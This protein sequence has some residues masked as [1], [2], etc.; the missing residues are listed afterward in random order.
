MESLRP[1]RLPRAYNCGLREL[2]SQGVRLGPSAES[3]LGPLDEHP[4]AAEVRKAQAK[5]ELLQA[6]TDKLEGTNALEEAE[7]VSGSPSTAKIEP[8]KA[9]I[10]QAERAIQLAK[11][12]NKLADIVSERAKSV[13][14]ATFPGT[15]HKVSSFSTPEQISKAVEAKLAKLGP[16]PMMTSKLSEASA[17]VHFVNAPKTAEHLNTANKVVGAAGGVLYV[18]GLY[19]AFSTDSTALDKLTAI[20]AR[21]PYLGQAVGFVDAVSHGDLE[22]EAVNLISLGGLVVAE[23][24]PGV[25]VVVDVSML[26]YALTEMAVSEYDEYEVDKLYAKAKPERDSLWQKR[27][28]YVLDTQ[29][30]PRYVPVVEELHKR[31]QQSLVS[32]WTTVEVAIDQQLRTH[33]TATTPKVEKQDLVNAAYQA[34]KNLRARVQQSLQEGRDRFHGYLI[35][36]LTDAME[37]VT[38]CGAE[39]DCT[40]LN[41]TEAYA[42]GMSAKA[43]A[44]PT[45]AAEVKERL[46][47]NLPAKIEEAALK[48]RIEEDVPGALEVSELPDRPLLPPVPGNRVY[49]ATTSPYV[50]T[51]NLANLSHADLTVVRPL[52]GAPKAGIRD[53]A[54]G[55]YAFTGKQCYY[56]KHSAES[57]ILRGTIRDCLP[58]L[59]EPFSEGIDAVAGWDVAGSAGSNTPY[60][61]W[62]IFRNGS[63]VD[64]SIFTGQIGSPE[65]INLPD[66]YANYER[67]DAVVAGNAEL[68]KGLP[69]DF[70][71]FKDGWFI[72][73][74]TVKGLHGQPEEASSFFK[75]IEDEIYSI[76]PGTG[77][78]AKRKLFVFAT[79]KPAE[80]TANRASATGPSGRPAS[81][82]R[83]SPA[84]GTAAVPADGFRAH[85]VPA[86]RQHAPP[87]VP[88]QLT[89]GRHGTA[90][91]GVP[92]VPARVSLIIPAETSIKN[93]PVVPDE[94]AM[95]MREAHELGQPYEV[96]INRATYTARR[97][98]ANIHKEAYRKANP[99]QVLG[100]DA[101]EIPMAYFEEGGTATANFK[102]INKSH[103][104]SLGTKIPNALGQ[105]NTKTNPYKVTYPD[106]T[107]V[108]QVVVKNL[109][110]AKNIDKALADKDV[111]ALNAAIAVEET[112][113]THSKTVEALKALKEELAAAP[114]AAAS[115]ALG[116]A[117][118]WKGCGVPWRG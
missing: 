7:L 39:A 70:L 85:G 69:R 16:H 56:Q 57:M 27:L 28:D 31:Y 55:L 80:F 117:V 41:F 71:L 26:L 22:G 20:T 66:A 17:T 89:A 110:Q 11:V 1:L 63:Y 118:V 86:S 108:R 58:N 60:H 114:D 50:A 33:I 5:A 2:G 48:Q 101:D 76:L 90:A 32:T 99:A 94:A 96:T 105:G 8:A 49:H 103:N 95:H 47:T 83:T 4:K 106:G 12:K 113:P 65:K 78:D 35:K 37:K 6:T 34:K 111:S 29:V 93:G 38:T 68:T 91:L 92:P 24:I 18:N 107:K 15:P 67:P 82:R 84:L 3:C 14:S 52:I 30:I 53:G 13:E 40:A 81:F 59:P 109:D 25:D 45:V 102:G 116:H 44:S 73:W 77:G 62:R 42:A 46:I 87:A 10:A 72:R 54:N 9:K 23:A 61:R 98:A 75:G 21:E 43:G 19:Q 36:S 74:N 100:K 64:Y 115:R 112:L 88:R 97:A 51:G 79:P 104:R